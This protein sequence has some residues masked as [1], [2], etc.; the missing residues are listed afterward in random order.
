L[1]EVANHQPTLRLL[2]HER[3]K[4][5]AMQAVSGVEAAIVALSPVLRFGLNFHK[6]GRYGLEIVCDEAAGQDPR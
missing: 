2:S 5:A 6:A 3:P 4:S 1:G